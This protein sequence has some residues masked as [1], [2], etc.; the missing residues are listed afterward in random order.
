M[1]ILAAKP[2]KKNLD[3]DTVNC[4]GDE[5][6][7]FDQIASPGQEAR[8]SLGTSSEQRF[9]SKQIALMLEAAG[10]SDVRFADCTSYSFV[11]G[12]KR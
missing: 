9:T 4:F 11:V 10:L 2:V 1:N 12:I 7:Q 6:S 8:D 3:E 5:W